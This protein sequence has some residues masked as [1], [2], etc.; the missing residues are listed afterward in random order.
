MG[1]ILPPVY[2]LCPSQSLGG[3]IIAEAIENRRA[4]LACVP[5]LGIPIAFSRVVYADDG[6]G[7]V[8]FTPEASPSRRLCTLIR[9]R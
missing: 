9:H 1:R 4:L 2:R 6:S 5:T 3:G 8:V 7:E